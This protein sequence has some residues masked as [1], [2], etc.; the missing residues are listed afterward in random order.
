MQQAPRSHL[1]LPTA[2]A[3]YVY[4]PLSGTE[5][6][7]ASRIGRQ[8]RQPADRVACKAK[9]MRFSQEHVQTH[10]IADNPF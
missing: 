9:V 6:E 4:H 8:A 7:P 2:A 1:S 3:A 5:L 10:I